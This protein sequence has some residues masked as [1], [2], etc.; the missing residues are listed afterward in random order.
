MGFDALVLGVLAVHSLCQGHQ[1]ITKE[2]ISELISSFG[3]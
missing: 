1:L 3:E 2:R